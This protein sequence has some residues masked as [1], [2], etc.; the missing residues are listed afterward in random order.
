MV[1]ESSMEGVVFL[2][3][4]SLVAGVCI[5]VE[6]A[7]A[8]SDAGVEDSL[9]SFDISRFHAVVVRQSQNAGTRFDDCI[10]SAVK[11]SFRVSRHFHRPLVVRQALYDRIER[12][13]IASGADDGVALAM[14]I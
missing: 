11:A 2:V 8:R 4:R 9:D 1:E 10:E 12:G 14:A 3:F 5:G 13:G 6:S 7:G